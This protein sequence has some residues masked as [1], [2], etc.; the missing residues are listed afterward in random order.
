MTFAASRSPDGGIAGVKRWWASY[1]QLVAKY[2]QKEAERVELAGNAGGG[3]GD[4]GEGE[5]DEEAS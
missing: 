1:R 3:E 4:D 2:M 5:E